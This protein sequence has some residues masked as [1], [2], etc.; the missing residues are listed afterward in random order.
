MMVLVRW[1][2]NVDCHSVGRVPSSYPRGVRRPTALLWFYPIPFLFVV[3]VCLGSLGGVRFDLLVSCSF[4]LSLVS[5]HLHGYEQEIS[6]A[7]DNKV[8][9]VPD[10]KLVV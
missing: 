3:S 7:V 4:S 5:F 8:P 9:Q 2:Y 1:C 10:H 6:N